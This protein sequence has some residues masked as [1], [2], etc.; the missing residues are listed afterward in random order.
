VSLLAI[1]F[2]EGLM[3]ITTVIA[4][5]CILALAR[6]VAAAN[7]ANAY[8]LS[9]ST[10]A[11]AAMLGKVVGDNCA[12][13][14]AFY[15]GIGVSG[16]SK[17]K[18]FWSVRCQDGREFAVEVHADGNGKVLEC[19]VLKALNAGECFKKLTGAH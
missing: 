13:K 10:E 7:G 8:L 6:P 12:G 1:T 5:I 19:T 18:A 11:R 2:V 15:M 17:D 3:K 9:I 14:I 4:F 16:F